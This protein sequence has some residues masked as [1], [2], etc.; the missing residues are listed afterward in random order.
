VC[1]TT[2]QHRTDRP[3]Q[4]GEQTA[5]R[6][7]KRKLLEDV[8]RNEEDQRERRYE[9]VPLA[10][11]ASGMSRKLETGDFVCAFTFQGEVP[12]LPADSKLADILFDQ[13][14]FVKFRYV[15]NAE[16]Q[17][18]YDLLTEPD[19][20]ISIDLVDPQAY[21][22]P[23]G[24]RLAPQDELL[25]S[26]RALSRALGEQRSAAAADA[27]SM[28]SE[29][30]WL[31][32]TPLMGNNLYDAVHK[33]QKNPI[34]RQHVHP[35]SQ[36]LA[37]YGDALTSFGDIITAI[38]Q[39]FAKVE[40][41]QFDAIELPLGKYEHL[42][43]V[44]ILPVLPDGT[45]WE[46]SYV[47]A[48]FGVDPGLET[49]T[50]VDAAYVQERVAHAIIKQFRSEQRQNF[51]AH[52][53]PSSAPV[54]YGASVLCRPRPLA[55]TC[56]S[57][58]LVNSPALPPR[59]ASPSR[60]ATPPHSP[61]AAHGRPFQVLTAVRLHTVCSRL[62]TATRGREGRRRACGTRVGA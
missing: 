45:C 25:L 60:A 62:P 52:S 44:E 31:R 34:E 22:A 61:R 56:E 3:A 42:T 9:S 39:S 46:N 11:D 14:I 19:L 41:L 17:A 15:T 23:P 13:S 58:L 35:Q 28:R 5:K 24:V 20:G 27:R 7:D 57:H 10:T 43:P 47:Q 1:H 2:Q 16:A 6:R 49:P 29:V 8:G 51:R 59:C 48:V 18:R 36:A 4:M 50:D 54:V 33:C 38:E 26:S 32:K 55:I 12:T 21:G 37:S 53:P 30:T 40:E